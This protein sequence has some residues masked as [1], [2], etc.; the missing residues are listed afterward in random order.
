MV[1]TVHMMTVR[2]NAYWIWIFAMLV[3]MA[4]SIAL[5][6]ELTFVE[7]GPAHVGSDLLIDVFL[8][9]EQD[10]VNALEGSVVIPTSMRIK[11]IRFEGSVVSL[12]VS[13]PRTDERG[14]LVFAGL[15]PGGYQGTPEKQGRGN[16]MTIVVA[17]AASGAASFSFGADTQVLLND[18]EGSKASLT[19]IPRTVMV[20]ANDGSAT[21]GALPAD[22]EPPLTFI[23]QVIDGE[24]YGIDAQV[25]I[26]D[27]Q[28]KETGIAGYE[29]AFT[30]FRS[31]D[32]ES[33]AWHKATSPYALKREEL[34]SY[35]HV[36]AVDMAG[37]Y[38][39][40]TLTPYH[41][42]LVAFLSSWMW[43]FIA[44]LVV[45]FLIYRHRRQIKKA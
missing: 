45:L 40:A 5:G 27:A 3:F 28:D 7:S 14:M 18:G 16:V 35:M 30:A 42:S 2:S 20:G 8:D 41:F 1:H 12:W 6:A 39:V 36:R 9:T 32:Y 29:I 37:N 26:F 22:V 21:P 11:D 17:P 43:Y 10:T 24:P 33:M 19:L 31:K 15:I 44:G 13:R 23:P 38:R 34:S 25:L 4:P